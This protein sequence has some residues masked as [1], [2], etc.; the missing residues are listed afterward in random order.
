MLLLLLQLAAVEVA[1]PRIEAAI[2]VD[3]VLD[4]AVWARAARLDAFTQYSPVDGRP[5]AQPTEVLVWYSPTALHFGIRATAEAGTVRA[6]LTDRDRGIIPDDYIEIQL[7]TFNDRRSA[8]VFAVNPLGV[9]ADGSLVEGNQTRRS[10]IEGDR[11]GGR[12]QADLSPDYTFDSRGRVTESGYEIEI[13]I[14]FRS[15]R[16]QAAEPQDWTLQIIRKSAQSGRED[17]WAPARR[18][19]ASFLA[20]HGRLVGLTG[21][22]R[23]LVLE[24][25]P[26]VTSSIAGAPSADGWEYGGGRPELGGN[27]KWGVSTNLTLN[28]TANPDFSQVESDAGQVTPDPRRAVFFAEKR[29]FFLDGLEYF[30]TPSQVIYTRRIAAPAAA[31]KVTGKVS[32]TSFGLLSAVDGREVSA[33]GRDRPVF[34]LVRLLRDVGGQSR[35]GFAYT[36]RIEGSDYN[37]VAQVDGRAVLGGVTSI[38]VHGAMSR[39]RSGGVTTTAP[40]WYLGVVHAGRRFGFNAAFQAISDRF[41]AAS[42]F[43]AQGDMAQVS[44]GPSLTLYGRHGAFLER[45][46]ASV[47]ATYT[48][49][50]PRFLDGEAPRDRQYWFSGAWALR[51]GYNLSAT[52]FVETFGYDERLFRDYRLEQPVPGGVDTVGYGVKPDLPVRA[53]MLRARTPEVAGFAFDGFA[54][55]GRDPN[56]LE[57]SRSEIVYARLGLTYRPTDKLRFEGGMPVLIHY[58][59][60]D[61]SKVDEAILPRLKVEY[62][63]SRAVFLRAVGEYRSLY[64]DDLRDDARTGLP[65]LVRDPADGIAKRSLALGSR[66][67]T[68]QVDWLFSFQP[69]PGTV[70]FA[71]YGSSLADEASFRFRGLSRTRDGFFTKLSYLFRM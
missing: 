16:Y 14:P 3:G 39:T 2:A 54:A 22:R 6:H 45:F 15:L 36:D 68:L 55:Y 1:P 69:T 46:N 29:P 13:R 47:T 66:S 58:R 24:L 31:V 48:W 37:R 44:L 59:R 25:N 10:A 8:F 51:G 5:A 18:G 64:Q 12:E 9:Q 19:A 71:G 70:F 30:S 11:T 40:L 50:Y 38:S 67:N 34:N 41:E 52:A 17:T 57:W 28:G 35:I 60:T 61:G 27:V 42:G 63:L 65:I 26:I 49:A 4:E 62:Q 56:Y 32:G 53:V 20:Q 7:G 33:S 43:L 23:G 21:L